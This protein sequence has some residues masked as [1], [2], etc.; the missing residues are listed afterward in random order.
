MIDGPCH[1]EPHP[2]LKCGERVRVIRGSLEGIEGI[3]VRK[4]NPYRLVLS[5]DLLARSRAAEIDAADVEPADL[6]AVAAKF[7]PA[8]IAG[9]GQV[10]C[11]LRPGDNPPSLAT[12][13]VTL[14]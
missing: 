13:K 8:Q 6:R 7:P 1:A 9:I 11:R 5:M 14:A 10:N 2:Y 3:L 4:K 12:D